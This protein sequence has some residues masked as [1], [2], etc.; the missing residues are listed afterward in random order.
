MGQPER[1]GDRFRQ[2]RAQRHPGLRRAGHR[3]PFVVAITD[4]VMM[5]YPGSMTMCPCSSD[6]KEPLM[7]RSIESLRHYGWLAR[8]GGR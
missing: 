5:T 7:T 4:R 8:L 6:R 2:F 1:S 3:S